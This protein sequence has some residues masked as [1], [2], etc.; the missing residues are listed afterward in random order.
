[1]ILEAYDKFEY[2]YIKLSTSINISVDKLNECG[3]E[4]WELIKFF[5]PRNALLGDT[6]AA[7][8]KRK[9]TRTEV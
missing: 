8:L 2:K 1:M 5:E 4:G 7:L 9:I 3:I 6:F